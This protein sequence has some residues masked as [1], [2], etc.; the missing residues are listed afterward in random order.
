M[1]TRSIRVPT[2]RRF[3]WTVVGDRMI[4]DGT[5]LPGRLEHGMGTAWEGDLGLFHVWTPDSHNVHMDGEAFFT[6]SVNVVSATVGGGRF[7]LHHDAQ[8]VTVFMGLLEAGQ[9]T[10]H[11]ATGDASFGP[12][13][14][15][16]LLPGDDYSGTFSPGARVIFVECP[17]ELLREYDVHKATWPLTFGA[18][19]TLAEPIRDFAAAI[20]RST[21]V[22]PLN[23]YLAE[24]L[25]SEMIIGATLGAAGAQR[26][27]RTVRGDTYSEAMSLVSARYMDPDFA[28]GRL[29]VLLGMSPRRLQQVFAGNGLQVKDAIRDRRLTEARRMLADA[30]HRLTS[31]DQIAQISGF[32]DAL[33]MR[34]AFQA[35]QLPA[36]TAYRAAALRA[37]PAGN[38]R[39]GSSEQDPDGA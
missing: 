22:D 31:I 9:V 4:I 34:R 35:V 11:L 10:L 24:Q 27:Q 14:G 29:A 19:G 38:G 25:L 32:G 23:T 17:V 33:R 1:P 37:A 5:M 15:M 39:P 13:A 8:K 36:P 12:G 28:P 7:R 18:E 20:L 26:L 3:H 2:H 21:P 30:N 6:G 16:A